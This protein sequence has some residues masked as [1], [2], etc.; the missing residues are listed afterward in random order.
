[1]MV[2]FLVL[3]LVLLVLCHFSDGQTFKLMRFEEQYDNLAADTDLNLYN[4]IKYTRLSERNTSI[5][6]SLGG[7]VRYE[8]AGRFEENWIAGQGYNKSLLQRY[9]LHAN[10]Q[11]G[12]RVRVF[13]QMVSGLENGSKYGSGPVDE[14][15]LNIQNLFA[16][17]KVWEE[18]EK[19]FSLR[20][21]RQEMN[22]G[23]GR[24][25]SV[26]EGTNIRQY[27][28][29]AKVMFQ[30][31]HLSIDG[32]TMM[33]DQVHPGVLD[34]K[35]SH[36]TDLWGVYSAFTIPKAGNIDWYYLGVRNDNRKFEEGVANELRHTVALRYWKNGGGFIYN[37]EGAF[38]WGKFGSGNI[39]AWTAALEAGYVFDRLKGRPSINLRH[40]YISGDRHQGDGQ[41]QTFNPLYPRGGYFGFNPLV[42]PANLIDLHPYASYSASDKLDLQ[43]D[44]VLNWRYSLQDGIY[45]PSGNFN[46]GGSDSKQRYIGTTYLLSAEYR[47]GRFFSANM[48]AQYFKAGAFIQDI[49][50]P[51]TD[52][53]FYNIQFTF[54]F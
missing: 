12:S 6:L 8:Y 28:T 45:R 17:W 9:S 22:Y 31:K 13:T 48:G 4:A 33:A 5:Y 35:P 19:G 38:Q 32:F 53:W 7:E 3:L 51:A 14:D 34:N 20:V 42:G 30:T 18:K 44:L 24:L 47:P 46:T 52:S 39:S 10:L 11:L 54:K 43:A 25:I 27:F 21:G 29:G 1:M 49:L 2:K 16:E 40:D 41:L 50:Q 36:R 15:Q 26:R 23:T 37:L